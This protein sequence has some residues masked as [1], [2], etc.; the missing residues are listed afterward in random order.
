MQVLALHL[1]AS[2]GLDAVDSSWSHLTKAADTA[3]GYLLE[4]PVF[5][6]EGAFGEMAGKVCACYAST[7]LLSKLLILPLA[8]TYTYNTTSYYSYNNNNNTPPV[9]I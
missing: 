6:L 5:G 9:E 3:L 7:L 4:N 8:Y 1:I 2:S